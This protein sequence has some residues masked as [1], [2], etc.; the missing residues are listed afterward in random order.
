M[1]GRGRGGIAL[2]LRTKNGEGGREKGMGWVYVTVLFT[3]AAT[4]VLDIGKYMRLQ[5]SRDQEVALADQK[6]LSTSSSL[7]A[8]DT[9]V[10][11]APGSYLFA[12]RRRR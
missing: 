2:G 1:G 9:P 4:D 8:G 7:V 11:A 6:R 10:C 3:R 12:R 5:Y